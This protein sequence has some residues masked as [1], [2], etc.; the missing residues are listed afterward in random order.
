MHI[1]ANFLKGLQDDKDFYREIYKYTDQNNLF[2]YHSEKVQT[3]YRNFLTEKKGSEL[4]EE[5][6]LFLEVYVNGA[7]K[8]I[9]DWSEENFSTSVDK[10]VYKFKITIPQALSVYI[11][12]K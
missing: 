12:F 6:Q 9:L 4:T 11:F 8:L 5:E 7:M 10:M 3:F 1:S 2:D